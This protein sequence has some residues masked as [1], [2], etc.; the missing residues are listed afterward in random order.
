M[1]DVGIKRAHERGLNEN[2][3]VRIFHLMIIEIKF[4]QANAEELPYE[5]N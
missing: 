4:V 2:C 3:K 1:L 5:D